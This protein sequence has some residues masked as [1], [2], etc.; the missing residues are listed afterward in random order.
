MLLAMT[1]QIRITGQRVIDQ[2]NSRARPCLQDETC[3]IPGGS[4]PGQGP[5]EDPYGGDNN[6]RR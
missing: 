5:S 1:P 2:E 3:A 4:V 6:R